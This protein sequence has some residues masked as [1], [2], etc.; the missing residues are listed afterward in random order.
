[1]PHMALN[2]LAIRSSDMERCRDFYVQALG[3]TEGPRPPFPF[4]GYWLYCGGSALIHVIGA[5][6]DAQGGLEEYLGHR[7]LGAGAVDHI[8]LTADDFAAVREC[9]ERHGVPYR[10]RTVPVLGMKQ[11]FVTDPDGI[12]L[13]LNFPLEPQ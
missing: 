1:M 3:F 7:T 10:E 6:P 5:E 4:P 12:T 9:L 13:E 8:A 11:L 2:H